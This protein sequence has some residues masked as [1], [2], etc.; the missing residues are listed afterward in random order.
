M[1]RSRRRVVKIVKKKLPKVFDC[2]KCGEN[3]VRV[4]LDK[5]GRALVQCGTCGLRDEFN[6]T[7]SH[8]EVDVYCKFIDELNKKSLLKEA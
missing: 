2:P 6:V 1:G 3:S 8:E 5:N 7:S 4:S